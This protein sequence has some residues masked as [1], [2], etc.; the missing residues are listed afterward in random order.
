MTSSRSRWAGPAVRG[1]RLVGAERPLWGVPS[2]AGLARAV[3][4]P[5]RC[6]VP[7]DGLRAIMPAL[8]RRVRQPAEEAGTEGC[9][10]FTSVYAGDTGRCA[11]RPR[12][13]LA[14]WQHGPSTRRPPASVPQFFPDVYEARHDTTT[15][16]YWCAQ[17][18]P[19]RQQLLSAGWPRATYKAAPGMADAPAPCFTPRPG[20]VAACSS[21]A[22]FLSHCPHHQ[23]SPV[24]PTAA[25]TTHRRCR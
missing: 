9:I 6:P 1:C 18:R 22:E 4:A 2:G 14:S 25:C 12:T 19:T 5:N 10:L 15:S 7:C 20:N 21:T 3:A 24:P 8:A 11:E 23:A 13:L 16:P 17:P